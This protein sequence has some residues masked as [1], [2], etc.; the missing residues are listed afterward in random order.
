MAS[1]DYKKIGSIRVDSVFHA[2]VEEE[3]LPAI[4][5]DAD[6]FWSGI[7]AIIDELTPINREL[8]AARDALQAKIDDWHQK[9]IRRAFRSRRIPEFPSAD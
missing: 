6:Q 8:L 4:G 9:S 2:F 1:S 5:F 3:L 7:A